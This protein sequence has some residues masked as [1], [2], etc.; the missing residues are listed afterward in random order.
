[1]SHKPVFRFAPSPNG[2]LHLGHAFSALITQQRAR[3][4]G[5]QVLL[6]IEDIDQAR[7]HKQYEQAIYEDLEWLGF[8]WDGSVRRQSEYLN[9]YQD[10]LETLRQK[11]MLYP[12]F[13]TRSEIKQVLIKQGSG[14]S[15]AKDPDG[16]FLYPGIYKNFPAKELEK[17]LANGE[18][19]ALRLDM[20]KAMCVL[21]EQINTQLT[22][23]E[24]TSEGNEIKRNAKPAIWGDV[25]LSR[26]D[27]KCSYH[28]A[29]CVDDAWQGVSHVT[30]GRDLHA[31]TDL[32][33]LLQK[34]LDLPE[35]IYFHHRLIFNDKSEK[36]SKSVKSTALRDLRRQG[37]TV[38]DIKNMIG[39]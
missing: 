11:G 29:C 17:R 31:A 19:Y 28:I 18:S 37:C 24:I 1:M 6:R 3:D 14:I 27:I 15:H 32:H 34:L 22:I 20:Q 12:C 35:P 8:G 39:L 2:F 38:Q 33:R 16:S 5:G 23:R 9:A 26:K 7:C 13:A 36:L 30:R 4:I 21:N 10:A 25:V